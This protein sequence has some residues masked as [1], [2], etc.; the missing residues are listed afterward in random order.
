MSPTPAIFSKS[1]RTEAAQAPQTMFGTLRV[2]S[3]NADDV[4]SDEASDEV[5]S[6]A[7]DEVFESI[8][9]ETVGGV[10]PAR[11]IAN[12]AASNTGASRFMSISPGKTII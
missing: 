4:A 8:F 10:Q 1:P 7:E 6:I 5:A 11:V 2:T 9:T 12:P 3:V